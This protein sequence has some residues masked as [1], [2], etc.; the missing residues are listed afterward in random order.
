MPKN[1]TL[2]HIVGLSGALAAV[3]IALATGYLAMDRHVN[4]LASAAIS[5]GE[6]EHMVDLKTSTKLDEILRRL[7]RIET[8]LDRLPKQT[9]GGKVASNVT[10]VP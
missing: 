4:A 5:M 9:S 10:E 8:Q 1:A 6:V 3:V 7:G 2:Q